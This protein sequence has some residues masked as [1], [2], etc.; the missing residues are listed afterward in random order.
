MGDL[1]TLLTLNAAIGQE[2]QLDYT[3]HDI[4]NITMPVFS[5]TTDKF[6][7]QAKERPPLPFHQVKWEDRVSETDSALFTR[8]PIELLERVVSLL[9]RGCLNTFAAVNHDCR[10]LARVIQFEH[11]NLEYSNLEII[12]SLSSE[13]FKAASGRGRQWLALGPCI[14]R[15]KIN[16]IAQMFSW[17][18]NLDD[19]TL[20]E[21]SQAKRD[22]AMH[23]AATFYFRWYMPRVLYTIAHRLPNLEQLEWFDKINLSAAAWYAILTSPIQHLKL[24]RIHY[25]DMTLQNIRKLPSVLSERLETLD[26]ELRESIGSAKVTASSYDVAIEVLNRCPALK[27]LVWKDMA[28]GKDAPPHDGTKLVTKSH[29]RFYQS[30]ASSLHQSAIL[31]LLWVSVLGPCSN[32]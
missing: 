4:L 19:S 14:R 8:L 24:Y 29:L 18:H 21:L 25:D 10:L 12:Q 3:A 9:P 13:F 20:I 17:R 1:N 23:Q 5:G 22:A 2:F 15:L 16:T 26:I 6:E 30:A 27:K 32:I 31:V 28:L 11:L 7:R